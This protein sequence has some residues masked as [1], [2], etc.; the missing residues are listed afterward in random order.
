MGMI[1]IMGGPFRGI[2]GPYSLGM[3]K[4]RLRC[5]KKSFREDSINT[6]DDVVPTMI[7]NVCRECPQLLQRPSRILV[8]KVEGFGV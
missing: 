4:R 1:A 2:R 8:F 3:A 5:E 7:H 6:D